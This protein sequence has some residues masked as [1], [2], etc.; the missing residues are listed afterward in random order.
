[1]KDIFKV[2]KL[3]TFL[4]DAFDPGD[5]V[6][7]EPTSPVGA[8]DPGASARCTLTAV[9]KKSLRG[10]VINLANAIRLQVRRA[11]IHL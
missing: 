6:G 8:P 9:E 4:L 1:M 7:P 10:F 2:A 5:C 3:T 11:Y